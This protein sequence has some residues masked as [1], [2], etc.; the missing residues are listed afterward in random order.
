M[1]RRQIDWVLVFPVVIGVSGLILVVSMGMETLSGAK[2]EIVSLVS[3][4]ILATGLFGFIVTVIV[5]NC[6]EK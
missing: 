6:R 1:H 3:G 4:C 2:T 5:T